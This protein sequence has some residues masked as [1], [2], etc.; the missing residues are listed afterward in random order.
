MR[1]IQASLLHSKNNGLRLEQKFTVILLGLPSS[2]ASWLGLC[3]GVA[4][5]MVG[6]PSSPEMLRGCNA[7]PRR[8]GELVHLGR[9]SSGAPPVFMRS[10]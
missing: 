4:L 10:A 7:P 6:L 5:L 2:P 9:E 8:G 1:G 3:G